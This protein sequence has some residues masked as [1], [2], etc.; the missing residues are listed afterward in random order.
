MRMDR[1]TPDGTRGSRFHGHEAPATAL[2]GPRRRAAGGGV[3]PETRGRG[4]A[5]I[6]VASDL[7]P[8]S[9]AT[10][11]PSIKA[12]CVAGAG[13]LAMH[14]SI[15]RP[16]TPGSR[17]LATERQ[18]CLASRRKAACDPAPLRP[19]PGPI[20][21]PVDRA[22]ARLHPSAPSCQVPSV[23]IFRD[24]RPFRSP[25]I[26]RIVPSSPLG[27]RSRRRADRTPHPRPAPATN[28][29]RSI[30]RL[31]RDRLRAALASSDVAAPCESRARSDGPPP[32]PSRRPRGPPSR[33]RTPEHG[34][35]RATRPA[36]RGSGR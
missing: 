4:V 33:R 15:K 11:R 3:P 1:S 16:C 35:C 12:P 22:P 34:R 36:Q 8:Q 29:A 20:R 19:R 14:S 5:R 31:A 2:G 26:R 24:L 9:Q 23:A 10:L 30:R 6:T 13:D 21:P 17:A 25:P 32:T 28:T 18:A 7:A 27:L